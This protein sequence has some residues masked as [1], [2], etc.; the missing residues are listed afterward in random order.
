MLRRLG[1]VLFAVGIIAG[2]GLG[3][4]WYVAARP[5]GL[6]MGL[7]FG[8]GAFLVSAAAGWAAR[9]ILGGN[10]MPVSRGYF[11]DPTPG[12]KA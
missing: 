2:L 4:L 10:K 1:N 11:V 3:A 9:Y 7:G 12:G 8:L 6:A 5:G